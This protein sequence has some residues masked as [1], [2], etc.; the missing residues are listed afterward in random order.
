VQL[1]ICL[2]L[3]EPIDEHGLHGAGNKALKPRYQYSA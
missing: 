2:L 3:L 1:S